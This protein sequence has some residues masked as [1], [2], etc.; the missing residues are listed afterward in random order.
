MR[1]GGVGAPSRLAMDG[2]RGAY[3]DEIARHKRLRPALE[4]RLAEQVREMEGLEARLEQ[5]SELPGDNGFQDTLA[6]LFEMV[7]QTHGA[8]G[9]LETA[10]RTLT[11]QL[12]ECTAQ[13]DEYGQD[14]V[15]L[16]VRLQDQL[17]REE[18]KYQHLL[19]SRAAHT[20]THVDTAANN[21]E[22]ALAQAELEHAALKL[23][24]QQKTAKAS[25]MQ[26]VLMAQMSPATGAPYPRP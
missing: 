23:D 22:A 24:L 4:L 8:R 13:C 9:K 21:A 19:A 6:V 14:R 12:K 2:E 16:M 7:A 5:L 3:L 10:S 1:A 17:A 18:T 11:N 20:S 26:G 15:E 25:E